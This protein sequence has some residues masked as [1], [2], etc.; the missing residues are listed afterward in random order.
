MIKRENRIKS[1]VSNSRDEKMKSRFPDLTFFIDAGGRYSH[2]KE[3]PI[4]FGGVA[5][6]TRA[7]SEIRDSLLTAANGPLHKWSNGTE[8]EKCAQ[9]IFRLLAKRQLLGF[10]L[11]VSKNTPEWDQ[12]FIEGQRLYK[13]GVQES[14]QRMPYAKPMATFKLHQFG[15]LCG[16]L[17]GFFC[18]RHRHRLPQKHSPIQ[19]VEIT[20]VFDSDIHGETN[21]RVCK[22][23]FSEVEHE[24]KQTRE[25]L[26]INPNIK[27]EIKTEQEE[28]LLLLP[29]Y[30]AGYHYSRVAYDG[31]Q[32]NDWASLV[33]A[34]KP[35]VDRLPS[36]CHRVKEEPF[37]EK[38][39]LDP[40]TFDGVLPQRE[41][42][43]KH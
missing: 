17:L 28:P 11:I 39:L 38:Y 7:V 31:Q 33:T 25:H 15:N 4:V 35:M 1:V 10:F 23:V 40:R 36:D 24:M 26:R 37:T 18:F 16:E 34:V 9:V 21:Q 29:D 22:K 6:E 42:P 19:P 43:A 13:K 30:L 8:T 5:V 3:V 41:R 2:S 14:Q 12:Y 32:E 27:A 20:A